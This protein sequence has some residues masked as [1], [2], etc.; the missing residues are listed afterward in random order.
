MCTLSA[1]TQT[2]LVSPSDFTTSGEA[3]LTGSNCFQLTK[4]RLWSSGGVWHKTPIDLRSSFSMDLRMMFGCDDIG[5]ADGVVFVFTPF[6]GMV[7]YQGEGMGF[8]GLQPSLGIEIDTWENEHLFDPPEDHVAILQDGYVNHYYNLVGPKAI[9]NVED[10]KLHDLGIRWDEKEQLLEVSIDGQDVIAYQGD[11][12]ADVFRDNPVV[13]WGVTSATGKYFN[14]HEICFDRINFRAP[15]E[16]LEFTPQQI[17]LLEKGQVHTL[18]DV[19]F[20][21]GR[22]TISDRSLPDLHRVINFLNDHPHLHLGIEGHTDN[23]GSEDLNKTLSQR[24]AK[25]ISDYLL[26][27]GVPQPRLHVEG[28]G[29]EHPAADNTTPQG[30]EKNRRIDIYFFNPRT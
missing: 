2:S 28:Y 16:D 12:I 22:T 27:K 1:L 11:L 29:E 5:G 30:R 10:C 26:G 25:A 17:G 8:A 14:R 13:Y 23:V 19:K 9:A 15:L 6:Q 20:K 7:G 18:E 3:V 4:E 21:S 24:R